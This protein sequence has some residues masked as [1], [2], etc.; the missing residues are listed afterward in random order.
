MKKI[1]PFLFVGAIIVLTV[2]NFCQD[3]KVNMSMYAQNLPAG[4]KI[5]TVNAIFSITFAPR[6]PGCITAI[7]AD[8]IFDE[9]TFEYLPDSTKKYGVFQHEVINFFA[10]N[11]IAFGFNSSEN[12][13]GFTKDKPIFTI[14]FKLKDEVD[15]VLK[16]FELQN[17]DIQRSGK[18]IKFR[19]ET[20]KLPIFAIQFFLIEWIVRSY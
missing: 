5:D 10:P 7:G 1:V 16:Y 11:R 13:C 15:G 8:I 9:T 20:A 14:A 3:E 19:Q 12:V 17:V 6:Y 18:Q 4:V 2:F